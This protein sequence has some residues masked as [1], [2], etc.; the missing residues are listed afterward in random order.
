MAWEK[1]RPVAPFQ[2]HG[3]NTISYK[4]GEPEHMESFAPLTLTE[5]DIEMIWR[6]GKAT[7]QE[8]VG[9]SGYNGFEFRAF[10]DVELNLRYDGFG[11]GRSGITFYWL[12]D[13]NVR[14]PMFAAEIDKLIKSGIISNR[15]GGLWSAEKRGQ[16][17]GIKLEK[18]FWRS[19]STV[20][21]ATGKTGLK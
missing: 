3:K 19:A 11:R 15:L 2:I 10:K 16:N 20:E 5:D 1:E 13:S 18:L 17:Y 12:D 21:N 4:R 7:Y 8:L 6:R 14:Y 9:K